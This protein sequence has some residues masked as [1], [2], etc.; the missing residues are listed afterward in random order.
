MR[1]SL[2]KLNQWAC[3]NKKSFS[4]F[5]KTTTHAKLGFET[6]RKL[7]IRYLKASRIN[8]FLR[9]NS[10]WLHKKFQHAITDVQV[11]LLWT[12][13]IPLNT[14]SDPSGIYANCRTIKVWSWL[15]YLKH[16][17]KKKLTLFHCTCSKVNVKLRS[18]NYLWNQLSSSKLALNL[19]FVELEPHT[20]ARKT[21]QPCQLSSQPRSLDQQF[22]NTGGYSKPKERPFSGQKH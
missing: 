4:F 22:E 1:L 14:M 16:C 21:L 2:K 17:R 10:F 15:F 20:L 5:H 7:S 3:W 12:S 19:M 9:K 8:V 11:N 6:K 13:K 18:L